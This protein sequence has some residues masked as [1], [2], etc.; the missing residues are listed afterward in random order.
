[1]SSYR[2]VVGACL[3]FAEARDEVAS[4]ANA[5][6]QGAMDVIGDEVSK[7]DRSDRNT[8]E[9]VE[10]GVSRRRL[11]RKCLERSRRCKECIGW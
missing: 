5:M 3:C 6:R 7:W 4:G 11:S 8:L 9:V 2:A 1:M 10:D